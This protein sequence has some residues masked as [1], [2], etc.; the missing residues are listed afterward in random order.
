MKDQQP[1]AGMR[2][3]PADH[4]PSRGYFARAVGAFVP[5]VV[6]ASFEKFGFHT[7]EIMTSWETIVGAD[8]AHITRPKTIKWPRGVNG[9]T[10]DDEDGRTGGAT[11]VVACDPAFALEVSYRTGDIIDRIN[12]YFGYRAIAQLRVAQ[13]PDTSETSSKEKNPGDPFPRRANVLPSRPK[14][15]LAAALVCLEESVRLAAQLD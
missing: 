2:T 8:L 14:G 13:S 6:A 3:L 15:D 10:A 4:R 1:T 12:R 9:R 7:A 11:L 5:E